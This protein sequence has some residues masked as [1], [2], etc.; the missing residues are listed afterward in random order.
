MTRSIITNP[1]AARIT[2]IALAAVLAA[3]GGGGGGGS[4]GGCTTIDPSR[5]SSLPSCGGSGGSTQ[6]PPVTPG[7]P[8]ALAPLVLALTN[9]SG[10]AINTVSPDAPGII[11]ATVKDN[12]GVVQP[13]VTVTVTSTDK[14]A[15]FVPASGAALTDAQGVAR[16][17][18]PVGAQSGAYVATVVASKGASSVSA[19]L[20]YAVKYAVL[21]LSALRI[22]PSPLSAGG[23]ATV[24]V[25]V[26]NGPAIYTA[27]LTVTFTSTCAAN[28]RAVL[29]LP[30]LSVGGFATTSYVD[31]GCGAADPITASVTLGGAT[32]TQTGT[33]TTLGTT[34]G[35]IAFVSALPQNMA[36]KGTGGPGRQESSTVTF[37]VLDQSGKPVPGVNVSFGLSGT[38]GA[39]GTGAVTFSPASAIS[40]ADG[41]VVTTVF[42]GTVNTP[43]R[44]LATIVGSSPVVTTLSDQLVVSTGV[45][46]QRNFSLSTEVHNVEGANI[47]GCVGPP[48]SRVRV[49]MA[50]HFNNPV[51]DG[52]AVSFT[53]EGAAIGASCLTGLVDTQLTDGTVIKQ[54]GT[55]GEC[56]VSFCSAASREPD[57]RVTV[58]A[59]ALGDESY[60]EN[61]ALP[62]SINRYD[63]GETFDDLCEPSRNDAAIS[64][65]QANANVKNSAGSACSAPALGEIY[66]DSNG[67]GSFNATGDGV[68]N[69][70][71]NVDPAT[72]QTTANNRIS[73]VHVRSSLIQVM[74]TSKAAI[75]AIGA[76][77]LTLSKCVDGTA[78]VNEPKTITLAIRDTNPTVFPGNPLAGNI[79]PAGSQITATTTNGTIVSGLTSSQV[80]NTSDPS[81]LN[82][83]YSFRLESD[84]TQ[85]SASANPPRICTNAKT[86]GTLNITVTSPSGVTTTAQFNVTD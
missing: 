34:G 42:A 45:P 23:T 50:D 27:P 30:V 38:V 48:A 63:A 10:A 56:S 52:T 43:V 17:G 24:E 59:Y 4:A 44:V 41:T 66:I 2:A 20:N 53:A 49:S 68:Y 3:C 57:G 22:N 78:F 60:V 62:N 72:G 36:L 1:L 83:V 40:T 18:L 7:D 35:Q 58:M 37:K 21:S 5:P 70:V 25:T 80:P 29:G 65:G 16:I 54:K 55:P 84:A 69:G 12:S 14:N 79:L 46:T 67:N 86:N 11:V 26:Q 64:N 85:S 51:P 31:K 81:Y 8:A 74:S 39:S 15:A 47:D 32:A 33:I 75:T 6:N 9:E 71:L 82:W 19:T 13:N 61:P 73:T 28:G 76:S 77:S